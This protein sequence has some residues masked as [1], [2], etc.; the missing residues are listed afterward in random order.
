MNNQHAF[1]V[2]LPSNSQY[3]GDVENK[4][5]KF[6]AALPYRIRL[7]GDWLVGLAEILYTNSYANV[8][9]G[10]MSKIRLFYAPT[11]EWIIVKVNPGYYSSITD[12][13]A[14]I[15][16]GIEKGAKYLDTLL[17]D[18][19]R[20]LNIVDA[21]L[22]QDTYKYLVRN[23]NDFGIIELDAIRAVDGVNM[24]E[25]FKHE[26]LDSVKFIFD[27]ERVGVKFS[28]KTVLA[29]E[30][31]DGLKHTLGFNDQFITIDRNIA[32]FYPDIKAGFESLYVYCNIIE[33]QIVG[34]AL[35]PLLRVVN[36][37]GQ[38][39]EIIDKEYDSPHYCN[40]LQKDIN[41]IE[42]NIR[43]DMGELVNFEFGRVVVKLH[44][45]K[46]AL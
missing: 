35:A 36:L 2:T 1:Y 10:D 26:R 46:A 33:N 42:I 22:T 25:T 29:V 4:I 43:N 38:R 19:P 5:S 20:N 7:E 40:V 32:T 13:I 15:N 44:F 24:R 34:N 16:R 45:K 12:L 21:Q 6:R 23:R 3:T 17:D 18:R 28:S 27:G 30:L 39:L 8:T 14:A 11:N 9:D 41:E 31:S 37:Q